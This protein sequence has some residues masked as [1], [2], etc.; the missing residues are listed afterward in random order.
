MPRRSKKSNR[1][2][3]DPLN[4]IQKA[5]AVTNIRYRSLPLGQSLRPTDPVHILRLSGLTFFKT[6]TAGAIA[7]TTSFSIPN[8]INSFASRFQALFKEYCVIRIIVRVYPIAN[9]G[10]AGGGSW[11]VWMTETD[12]ATPTAA[13][14]LDNRTLSIPVALSNPNDRI[15]EMEW[16]LKEPYEAQW[17]LVTNTSYV[18]ANMKTY[19]DTAVFGGYGS[20]NTSRLMYEV[21]PTVLFRGYTAT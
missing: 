5:M 19:C 3:R 21:Y 13:D 10:S 7:S 17:Q 14:A 8:L 4:V 2:G 20:D 18:F 11:Q 9:Q 12:S 1:R 16:N 6:L 15:Y